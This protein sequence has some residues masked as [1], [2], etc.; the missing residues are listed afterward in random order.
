MDLLRFIK[1]DSWNNIPVCIV[2]SMSIIV[3]T[4]T[5]LNNRIL[6]EHQYSKKRLNRHS[7]KILELQQAS[8]DHQ[9]NL[10]KN[11]EAG[12]KVQNDK[13]NKLTDTLV[14]DMREVQ[15]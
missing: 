2:K 15:R 6:T 4:L 12:L 10:F 11:L 7:S 14:M 3:D 8:I 13:I 5:E 1:P 9:K